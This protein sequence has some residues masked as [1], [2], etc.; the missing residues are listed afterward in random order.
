MKICVVTFPISE[1]GTIPLSNLMTIIESISTFTC[2]ITGGAGYA[3]Y[4]D[5]PIVYAYDIRHKASTNL[6][7]KVINYLLTQLRIS[8]RLCSLLPD[9]DMC[10]FF[11]GG[12]GLIL[13]MLIA[14][15]L[16]RKVVLALAGV[17][18]KGSKGVLSKVIALLS[19][20]GFMIP[21]RIIIYSARDIAARG[22]YGKWIS[23][24]HEHFIDFDKFAVTK[25][26]TRRWAIGYV[27]ALTEAKGVPSLLEAI[28]LV[29]EKVQGAHFFIAGEGALDRYASN[30]VW[31]H[32]LGNAV[33][34]LG[35]IPHEC[36]PQYLSALRLLVLPSCSEGIPNVVLE[37]M[38][39]GTPVLVTA[40]GA[41]S[42]IIQDGVTGFILASNSVEDIA[43]GILRVLNHPNLS[44]IVQNAQALVKEKFSFKATLEGYR[45]ALDN[46]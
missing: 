46:V 18:S 19:R 15:L 11:I 3:C 24:A 45:R 5:D 20:I 13:P 8:Y 36:L 42:D 1:A 9:L 7:A 27:G 2:L 10:L 6:L 37:A 21:H 38:A 12:E 35:W 40:V 25:P 30:F 26:A 34:L 32:N 14:R 41:V 22:L 17:P 43:E 4:K 23:I 29:L 39:C 33:E 16:R 44:K 31:E 28:P